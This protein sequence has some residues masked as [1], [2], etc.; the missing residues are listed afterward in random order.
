MLRA[1]STP[2]TSS[3]ISAR[4]VLDWP[5]PQPTSNALPTFRV[6]QQTSAM[7]ATTRGWKYGRADAYL[8]AAAAL[9]KWLIARRLFRYTAPRWSTRLSA[10]EHRHLFPHVERAVASLKCLVDGFSEGR[11]V[12]LI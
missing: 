3:A 7:R 4:A 10:Q 2:T 1:T 12:Q 9:A 8:S 11:E 6:G 5:V